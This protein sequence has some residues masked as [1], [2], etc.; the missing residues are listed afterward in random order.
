VL[1][2]DVLLE[3]VCRFTRTVVM[4]A[5]VAFHREPPSS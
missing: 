1:V 4:R 3:L 2:L 5:V